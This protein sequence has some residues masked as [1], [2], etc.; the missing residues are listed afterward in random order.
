MTPEHEARIRALNNNQLLFAE[1]DCN[2][3]IAEAPADE[4]VVL[5]WALA[6]IV[7]EWRKRDAARA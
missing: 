5:A 7:D 2:Q 3:R 4:A 6:I 1:L